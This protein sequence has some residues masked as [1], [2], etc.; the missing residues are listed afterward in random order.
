MRDHDPWMEDRNQEEK[1]SVSLGRRCNNKEKKM[2]PGQSQN[3]PTTLKL[4][5]PSDKSKVLVFP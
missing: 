2:R 3:P 1:Q 5:L 4:D